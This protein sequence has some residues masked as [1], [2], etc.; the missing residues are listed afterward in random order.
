MDES[1]PHQDVMYVIRQT[2]AALA[3]D[4]ATMYIPIVAAQVIF[5]GAIG[6]AFAKKAAVATANSPSPTTFINVE[7][8]SI[9]FSAQ[10]FWI[11]PAVIVAS[12]IGVSQVGDSE[13]SIYLRAITVELCISKHIEVDSRWQS[14]QIRTR[15]CKK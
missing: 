2:A 1:Q 4:R 15:S 7:A 13:T 5:I 3:A 10:Y 14:L 11:I 6:V 12:V 9:S 8:H